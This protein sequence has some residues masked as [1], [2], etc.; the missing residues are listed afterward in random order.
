MKA[1]S[2]HHTGSLLPN[3]FSCDKMALETRGGK[4]KHRAEEGSL[5]RCP[6]KSWWYLQ[7]QMAK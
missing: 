5:L 6:S 2:G 1:V 4:R 3:L 7:R